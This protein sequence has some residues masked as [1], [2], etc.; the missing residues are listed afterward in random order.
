MERPPRR[1]QPADGGWGGLLRICGHF[2]GWG[3]K[4]QHG[5]I[6]GITVKALNLGIL[7]DY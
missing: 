5:M 2:G 7:E 3:G 4:N 1:K 6:W